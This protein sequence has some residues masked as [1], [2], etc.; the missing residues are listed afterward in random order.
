MSAR[1]DDLFA[2]WSRRKQAVRRIEAE[3]AA[4]AAGPAA[5]EADADAGRQLPEP[6]APEPPE[7][8]EPPPSLDDL[9]ADGDLSAF[10]REGVPAALRNAAMRKMWSLDPAIRDHVGLSEY[11]WDFNE[12]GAMTGF[13]PL[14]AGRAVADFLSK[15]RRETPAGEDEAAPAPEAPAVAPE[16]AASLPPDESARAPDPPEDARPPAIEV[17][18]VDSAEAARAADPSPTPPR[19]R[20]GSAV[21]R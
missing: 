14:E 8:P 17:A 9:T 21:P 12:P 5:A 13:G 10:L 4:D 16:P 15:V 6:P 11:A 7:P 2:R 1:G 20:H 18:A 3:E 19:P